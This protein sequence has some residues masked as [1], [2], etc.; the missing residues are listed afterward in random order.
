MNKFS[1]ILGA[2][3]V[4][5]FA[6]CEGPQGPPG[7]DGLDGLDGL[8]GADGI[9]GQVV[10]VEGVN[11]GYDA[12]ANLFSTLI[13]FSDVTDFEVFESD[14]VLVYRHDGIIDLNDGTTA[15]AWTQIPQNYFLN[16]GTIQYVFAHTFVD[17]ELFIDGNFD[18]STLST[19]FTDNQLFRIVFVPSEYAESPDFDASNIE[20][21][22]SHLNI[23][24]EHITTLDVN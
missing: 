3:I 23:D 9:Q 14:A 4:F 7:F 5:V 2:V 1:T 24:E 10:E 20:S 12:E 11:F 15:D 21:V 6:A 17:V 8:D 13:T 19:D 18:L 16:E 22:M